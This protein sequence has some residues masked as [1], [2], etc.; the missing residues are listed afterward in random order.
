MKHALAVVLL[1]V[2]VKMLAHSWLHQV[3]GPD[4]NLLLLAAVVAILGIGVLVSI[5]ELRWGARINRTMS[6]AVRVLWDWIAP[7]RMVSTILRA[8]RRS[9]SESSTSHGRRLSARSAAVTRARRIRKLRRAW[10]SLFSRPGHPHL[11]FVA[12][13]LA[14]EGEHYWAYL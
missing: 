2:G 8:G 14:E 1:T 13:R 3:L 6:S 9:V 11:I 5:V 4:F 12:H 7:D 10:R